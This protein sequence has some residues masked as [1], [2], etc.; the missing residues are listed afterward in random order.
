LN[1]IV[2]RL[3]SARLQDVIRLDFLSQYCSEA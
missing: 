1:R 3:Q 2:P